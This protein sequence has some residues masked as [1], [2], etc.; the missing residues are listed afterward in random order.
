MCTLTHIRTGDLVQWYSGPRTTLQER[1]RMFY[2]YLNPAKIKNVD[3]FIKTHRGAE[4]MVNVALMDKYAIDLSSP[5]KIIMR[6][7][8]LSRK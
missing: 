2:H 1:L 3:V 4:D 8:H 7:G 5:E 6:T